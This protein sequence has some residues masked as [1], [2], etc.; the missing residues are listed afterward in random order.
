MSPEKLADARVSF[1]D[2]FRESVIWPIYPE[3]A[4]VF[5][6]EVRP[7]NWTTCHVLEKGETFGLIEMLKR[8]WNLFEKSPEIFESYANPLDG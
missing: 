1:D 4:S 3:I 6:A 7:M 2:Y 5:S 8:S